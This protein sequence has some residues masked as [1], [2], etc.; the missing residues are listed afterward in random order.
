MRVFLFKFVLM[1]IS[2]CFITFCSPHFLLSVR[3]SGIRTCPIGCWRRAP[4]FIGTTKR[5]GIWGSSRWG[6]GWASRVFSP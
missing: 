2:P 6:C 4:R 1:I 3:G 5:E